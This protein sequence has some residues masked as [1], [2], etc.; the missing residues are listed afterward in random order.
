[1][2]TLILSKTVV[3]HFPERRKLFGQPVRSDGVRH[4]I[5]SRDCPTVVR[6]PEQIRTRLSVGARVRGLFRGPDTFRKMHIGVHMYT[7][8]LSKTVVGHF[9]KAETFRTAQGPRNLRKSSQI[10]CAMINH[11]WHRLPSP[12][13][14]LVGASVSSCGSDYENQHGRSL[15]C[16]A[17]KWCSIYN[18]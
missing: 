16:W 13:V 8:I 15:H 5:S 3:G 7:L 11:V 1:M 17:R 2:H 6:P 14:T 10:A 9:G 18:I 12:E 4:A